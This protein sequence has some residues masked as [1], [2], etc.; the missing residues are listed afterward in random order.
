M[1][2]Q[3][4]WLEDYLPGG[5]PLD[6]ELL[7]RFLPV[8]Q[9]EQVIRGSSIQPLSCVRVYVAHHQGDLRLGKRDVGAL[10]DDPANELVVDLA[11]ALLEAG[12]RM[13]VE[14]QCPQDVPV[15][16]LLLDRPWVGEF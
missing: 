2:F 9:R 4:L 3:E 16:R 13:A 5:D 14:H 10:G 12:T 15:M 8:D 11:G 6:A 1:L 7:K